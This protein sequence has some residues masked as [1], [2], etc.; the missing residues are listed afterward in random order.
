MAVRLLRVVGSRRLACGCFVGVYETYDGGTIETVDH[1]DP[2]CAD[3][4]HRPG[5]AVLIR[6][7]HRESPDS[8]EPHAT[9]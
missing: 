2:A 8:R 5:A 4:A 3:R 7:L 6:S 1:R 9:R